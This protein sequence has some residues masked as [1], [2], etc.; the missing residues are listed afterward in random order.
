VLIQ[1]AWLIVQP[2]RPGC[3][4]SKDRKAQNIR[5]PYADISPRIVPDHL[6][7]EQAVFVND[8]FPT[9]WSAII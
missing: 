1:K 5:V 4:E 3:L 2:M 7:D 9:G 6:S 8:I